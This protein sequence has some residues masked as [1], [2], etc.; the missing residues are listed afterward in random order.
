ML[1]RLNTIAGIERGEITLAFRR[2]RR[3]TVRTGGTLRTARGV[4]AIDA[5]KPCLPETLTVRDAKR[6]GHA[7]LEELFKAL[8][9]R[10]EGELYRIELHWAGADPRIALRATRLTGSERDGV[11]AK[12]ARLDERSPKGAWT[13]RVLEMIEAQPGVRAPDLAA[14]LR[15]PVP[16]FKQYVRKLK[17][18]GLTE[19]LEI[20]YRLS[21]RGR[22]ALEQLRAEK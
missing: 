4:V 20:G 9:Q 15:W 13:R 21:P 11:L 17:N 2:W 10:R 1:L 18:L 12:L 14:Q 5:V 7:T 22:D 3:P 16:P 6:A 19:S 8:D